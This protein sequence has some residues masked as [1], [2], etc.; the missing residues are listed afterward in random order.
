L[1]KTRIFG[2]I[3]CLGEIMCK[4][5]LSDGVMVW[6]GYIVFLVICEYCLY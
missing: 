5:V 3:F 2:F 6:V 4:W 1:L